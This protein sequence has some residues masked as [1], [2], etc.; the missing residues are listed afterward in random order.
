MRDKLMN[1]IMML[2]IGN[3]V[4]ADALKSRLIIILDKYE[5]T[6]RCTEVAVVNENDIERYVRL[7]LINKRVAGRTIPSDTTKMSSGDFSVRH[8]NH[9]WR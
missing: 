3:G 5:V 8:R 6:E 1:D 2:L 9:H 4:D 7:F